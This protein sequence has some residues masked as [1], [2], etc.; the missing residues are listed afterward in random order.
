MVAGEAEGVALVAEEPLS[1][2]G[3]LDPATGEVIDRRHHLSG[4]IVTGCVLVMPFSRGSS[5][6]SSVL[7]EAIRA[8]TGPAAIITWGVDPMLALGSI[9]AGELYHRRVPVVSLD[10]AGYRRLRSGDPLAIH[11]DGTVERVA[12]M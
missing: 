6:T 11:S 1:L 8:G 2:R 7:L 9:V 5:T 12:G 3:G 4:R 10:Q